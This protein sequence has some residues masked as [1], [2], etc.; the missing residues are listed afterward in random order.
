M[1]QRC[2]GLAHGVAIR[3]KGIEFFDAYFPGAYG[4]L[5]WRSAIIDGNDYYIP[6]LIRHGGDGIYWYRSGAGMNARLV[7]PLFRA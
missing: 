1:L 2:L 7:S 4:I 5:L 3:Q 6:S